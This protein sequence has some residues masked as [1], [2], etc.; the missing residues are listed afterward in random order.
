PA[1]HGEPDAIALVCRI[2]AVPERLR[3][4]AEHAAAIQPQVARVHR[5]RGPVAQLERG[6][7]QEDARRPRARST[8]RCRVGPRTG[9]IE[10]SSGRPAWPGARARRRWWGDQRYS[11]FNLPNVLVCVGVTPTPE[12]MNRMSE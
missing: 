9:A 6:H 7:S 12:T 3:H 1:A 8:G 4:R 5:V 11:A 2:R 10:K